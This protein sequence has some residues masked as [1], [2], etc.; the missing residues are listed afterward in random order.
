MSISHNFKPTQP[1]ATL[2]KGRYDEPDSWVSIAVYSKDEEAEYRGKGF[3]PTSAFMSNVD[4]A[5]GRDN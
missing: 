5:R 3:K 4:R 2:M 1:Y